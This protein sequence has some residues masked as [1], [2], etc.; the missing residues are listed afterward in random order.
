MIPI[1]ET[2]EGDYVITTNKQKMN[3]ETIHQYLSQ[4]SYWAQN[5]SIETVTR[6]IEHSFCFAILYHNNQIGFARLI[7]DY[8]TFA[9]LADVF[10]I[11]QHRGKGL[12]KK[13]LE[14]IHTNPEVQGLR[15]WMLGTKDAHRLYSKFGWSSIT[16]EQYKRFMQVHIPNVYSQ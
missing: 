14:F 9:Y 6:S 1:Y 11:E 16:E 13:L 2:T 12:A 10:I 8:A 5:I 7:T 15:R 4:E 3:V